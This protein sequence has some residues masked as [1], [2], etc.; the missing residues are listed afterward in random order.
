[1]ELG[2]LPQ[3]KGKE[4]ALGLDKIT[5]MPQRYCAMN[6]KYVVTPESPN[7]EYKGVK[8]YFFNEKSMEKWKA[9]T[10]ESAKNA[11]A[12]GILPQLAGK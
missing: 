1:M 12:V 11:I 6:Y 9:N 4:A 3:L 5:L 2:L 10:E 8:I 7:L